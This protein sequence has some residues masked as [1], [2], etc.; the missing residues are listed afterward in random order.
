MCIFVVVV[1][2]FPI[3][4]ACDASGVLFSPTH[5]KEKQVKS[6]PILTHTHTQRKSRSPALLYF[7]TLAV[8][9]PRLE[10]SRL[11]ATVPHTTLQF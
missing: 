2:F 3:E 1:F 4:G 5:T 6:S 8:K 11:A 10:T 9:H 7:F